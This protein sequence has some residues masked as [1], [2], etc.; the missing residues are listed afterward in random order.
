MS[1]MSADRN[2]RT[3]IIFL[4]FSQNCPEFCGKTVKQRHGNE[5]FMYGN[6]VEMN[7]SEGKFCGQNQRH[8]NEFILGLGRLH[9]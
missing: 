1:M 9:D 8:G 4:E 6:S 2:F 7:E 3:V 5:L